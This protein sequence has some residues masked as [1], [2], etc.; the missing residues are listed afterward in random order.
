[1]M[2]GLLAYFM[3]DMQDE[4]KDIVLVP[5]NVTK[6]ATTQSELSSIKKVM[7]LDILAG[8]VPTDLTTNFPTYLRTRLKSN[9]SDP[10]LDYWK[11]EY[12]ISEEQT[13]YIVWSNGPDRE[14]NTDDDI[15]ITISKTPR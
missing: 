2:I 10:S 8:E 15:E 11:E 3:Y 1:M 12:Q 13:E 7:Y 4:L 5:I 9:R 6:V 14:M